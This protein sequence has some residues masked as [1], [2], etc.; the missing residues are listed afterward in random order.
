MNS[1]QRYAVVT[2]AGSGI[3]KA[4]ALA[5]LADGY[6]VALAGRRPRGARSNGPRVRIVAGAG[7]ADGRDGPGVRAGALRQGP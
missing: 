4:V 6:T 2:G 5:L 1:R 3:G 7:R